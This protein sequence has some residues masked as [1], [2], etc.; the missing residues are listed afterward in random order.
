MSCSK[1]ITALLLAA[2]LCGCGGVCGRC[3]VSPDTR[4]CPVSVA[5]A[6]EVPQGSAPATVEAGWLSSLEAAMAEARTSGKPVLACFNGDPS[7]PW[8]DAFCYKLQNEVFNTDKF[9]EW[10]AEN[11]VLFQRQF[12]VPKSR[13]R[14]IAPSDARLLEKYNVTEFPTIVFLSPE[15]EELGLMGYQRGGATPWIEDAKTFLEAEE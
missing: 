2:A 8:G 1:T 10:A 14:T 12:P 4:T 15:G 11:V 6:E 7:D 9:K 5:A 3:G 13:D